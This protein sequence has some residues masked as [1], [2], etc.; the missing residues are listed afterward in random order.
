MRDNLSDWGT[1]KPV[2]VEAIA[3]EE[4]RLVGELGTLGAE[5]SGKAEP[6]LLLAQPRQR[7]AG[8]RIEGALLH[9]CGNLG[10]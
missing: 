4:R 1:P 3:H 7:R 10:L 6:A 2:D 5:R 8:Q 9:V